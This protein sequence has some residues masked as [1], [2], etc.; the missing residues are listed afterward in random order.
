MNFESIENQENNNDII[1]ETLKTREELD[2]KLAELNNA[3]NEEEQ[4]NILREIND[5][6]ESLKEKSEILKKELIER[7]KKKAEEIRGDDERI[8]KE[9]S[10]YVLRELSKD[11]DEYVR[12]RVAENP[13]APTDILKKLSEDESEYVRCR[14]AEN[15]NTPIKVLKKLSED[16]D[17]VVRRGVA[18]NPNAPTDILKKLS[19]DKSKY[20]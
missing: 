6:K 1:E 20:V 16:E 14:V 19:E 4:Q 13:N 11:E 17:D 2:L 8:Q 10:T 12:H 5:L 3:S 7:A 15:P 18:L 9:D